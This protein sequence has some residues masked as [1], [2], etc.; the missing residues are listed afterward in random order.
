MF[1]FLSSHAQIQI[2]MIFVI[3]RQREI[4]EWD[5]PDILECLKTSSCD[6]SMEIWYI[7]SEPLTLQT[8][9]K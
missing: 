7:W 4:E 9:N 2:Y 5:T 3:I 1:L 6:E 8:V